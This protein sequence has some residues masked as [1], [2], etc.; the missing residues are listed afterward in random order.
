MRSGHV[1][2]EAGFSLIET[3][4]AAAILITVLAGLAQ[5]VAWSVSHAREAG[6]R[7]RALVAAQDKLEELRALSWS[8]DL[9]GLPLSDSGLS[10][11]PA[12]S[13][14]T[15]TSGYCEF[16]DAAGRVTSTNGAVVVRRWAIAPLDVGLIDTLAITVCS[17]RPP[18][19]AVPRTAADVCLSTARVRQP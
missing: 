8:I 16:L 7:S 5:M 6:S 15:N 10:P 12:G 11:S 17:F 3:L 9:N 18:A 13:L 2:A 19:V 1:R 4:I 14:D